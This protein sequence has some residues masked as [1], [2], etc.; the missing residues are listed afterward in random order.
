MELEFEEKFI[1]LCARR[2]RKQLCEMSSV[3]SIGNQRCVGMSEGL[4]NR[5][6]QYV[7]SAIV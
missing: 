1:V 5:F 3:C 4:S 7:C 6:I 2:L